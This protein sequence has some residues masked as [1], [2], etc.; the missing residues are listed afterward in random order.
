MKSQRGSC[1]RHLD[2]HR[3]CYS[4]SVALVSSLEPSYRGTITTCHFF[5][6]RVSS[7]QLASI[8]LTATFARNG[9]D[10]VSLQ[11]QADRNG[12]IVTCELTSP[13][14]FESEARPAGFV[15]MNEGIPANAERKSI[16][17]EG[18]GK[19]EVRKP[20]DHI[21]VITD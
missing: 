16:L 10:R 5:S 20:L 6:V 14:N 18:V 11:C 13:R 19:D 1:S 17:T 2:C 9:D 7:A 21:D 4:R 8:S 15:S 3:F 12:F